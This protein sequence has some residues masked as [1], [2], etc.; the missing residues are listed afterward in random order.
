MPTRPFYYKE[1]RGF[2]VSV[3]PEYLRDDSDEAHGRF[4]FAYAVRIENCS[5]DAAQLMRRH[6]DIVDDIGEQY[7]VDGDGVVGQ[8][9]MMQTGDVHEYRSFC[10]LKSP[11]G[12]MAGYYTFV[13]HNGA[14]IDV[15]IPMF[16]LSATPSTE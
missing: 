15:Q 11:R 16:V 10:V 4:V 12:T 3:Y 8:Q 13:M 7:A 2:R 1:T 5:R 6:W 9:P 14:S